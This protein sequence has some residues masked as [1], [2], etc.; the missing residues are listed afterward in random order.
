MAG[1]LLAEENGGEL[2]DVRGLGG[3]E[4][5]DQRRNHLRVLGQSLNL[6]LSLAAGV[7]VWHEELNQQKLQRLRHFHTHCVY[8]A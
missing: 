4:V 7:V 5:V 1:D 3:A 2:T 6:I 8:G